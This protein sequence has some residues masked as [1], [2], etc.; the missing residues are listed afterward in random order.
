MITQVIFN[1]KQQKT[2]IPAKCNK[3]DTSGFQNHVNF[4]TIPLNRPTVLGSKQK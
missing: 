1:R 4:Y 2:K 3:I